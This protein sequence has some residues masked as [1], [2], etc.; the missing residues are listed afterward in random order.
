MNIKSSPSPAHFKAAA[1][2]ASSWLKRLAHPARLMLVCHLLEGEL[3]VG[4]LAKCA[5]LRDSTTSQHLAHLKADGIVKPRR[6]GQAVYYSLASGPVR[7]VLKALH[8]HFC[9]E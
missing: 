4:E 6:A 7:P 1:A 8:Q 3:T 9:Q 2:L 5:G